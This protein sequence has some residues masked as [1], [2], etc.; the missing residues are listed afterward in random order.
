MASWMML[1]SVSAAS[2]QEVSSADRIALRRSA[3]VEVFERTKNAVVNISTTQVIAVRS[4]ML[5]DS[6][7]EEMFDFP[8]SAGPTRE[9]KQTAVGSGFVIHPSGYI[10]TNAHVVMRTAER[11]VIFPDKSEYEADIVATDPRQ[12]LAILKISADRPLDAINLGRSDDLMVGESVIAI[13]NPLGL[14]TTVTTG[15]V[16]ALGR[17]L[18]IRGE[19]ALDGLIQTD[20][21]INPGNSGGPLL[22]ILGEL[23]GI[24]TA[25][26]GDAQNIGFAIPV[27]R[28]METLPELLSVERRYRIIVG[29]TLSPLADRVVKEVRPGTPAARARIQAGDVVVSVDGAPLLRGIDYDIALVGR[30]PGETLTLELDRQGKLYRT[31]ISIEPMPKPDGLMLAREKL[32]VEVEMLTAQVARKLELSSIRGMLIT[33]IEKDGP[34]QRAGLEAGDILVEIGPF[35]PRSLDDLGLLLEDLPSGSAV[36]VSLLREGK[37]LIYRLRTQIVTR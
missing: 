15:V 5:M 26:R 1:G 27:Q 6:L 14:D 29:L 4:S 37:R 9:L 28:L 11:K 13:G 36:T 25:I 32:G 2:A 31:A 35:V 18:E 34:A 20:A 10:V 3:V 33:R 17:S 24:T 23:I 16:S 30:K 12:D 7:L 8:G 22:N 19:V 21:S